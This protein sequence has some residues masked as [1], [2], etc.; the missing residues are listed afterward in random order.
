MVNDLSQ[1]VG[2]YKLNEKDCFFPYNSIQIIKRSRIDSSKVII[3]KL[4]PKLQLEREEGLRWTYIKYFPYNNSESV[5]GDHE[6]LEWMNAEDFFRIDLFD[7]NIKTE[8]KIIK[9]ESYFL[10]EGS[11]SGITQLGKI[12]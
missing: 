8:K 2:I 7:S 1:I 3:E 5:N 4:P 11:Y 9:D 6:Y 12:E 10:G